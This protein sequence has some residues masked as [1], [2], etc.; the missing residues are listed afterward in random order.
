MK[1]GLSLRIARAFAFGRHIPPGQL[2]RRAALDARRRLFDRIGWPDFSRE[3]APPRRDNPPLPLFSPRGG[4][5]TVGLEGLAFTFLSKTVAMRDAIDWAGPGLGGEHQLWRMNLHYMEYLETIDDGRLIDLVNQWIAGNRLG[6]G[7]WRD[8][9]NSYALSLRA[10]VWM[11]QIAQRGDKKLPAETLAPILASL[12]GQLRFLRQNLETD[13]GGNHLIKN[14]KALAWGAAFFNGPESD[15]WRATALRLLKRE[16]AR[17]ILAD[18]AHYERSPAYHAQVFADLLECRQ[19]LG[20]A[21]P[22]LDKALAGM[23]QTLADLAHPDGMIAQFNDAGLTMAYA[24]GE[25]LAAYAQVF[26][27]APAPRSVFAMKQAGYFGRRAGGDYLLVDCGR[28]APDDLPAHGH[29]DVLSFEWSVAGQRIIVDPGVFEYIAGPRRHWS[30]SALAHNTLCV[31]GADQAD[32]FGAFRCGRRPNVTLRRFEPRADGFALE[33]SHDGFAY[34]PGAPTHV[35]RFEADA[36]GVTIFDR[37]EG[38]GRRSASVRFLF[39]PDVAV[40][41]KSG[42]VLLQCKAAFIEMTS[43]LPIV[44]DEGFWWPDMGV[45][46]KTRFARIDLAGGIKSATSAFRIIR[47]GVADKG[48]VS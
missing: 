18:G 1:A 12:A 4:Q 47:D 43:D 37:V 13:L 19:V 36:A 11:Q 14:I 40:T 44:I 35:R 41:R 15:A 17:Q 3:N 10:V 29:G 22:E 27:Q 32:F 24:P 6:A 16:I 21:A 42:K 28:I 34:L 48:E 23:A 20:D 8:S 45:E 2:A 5:V 39:H 38:G 26:G 25:C 30:R 31:E 33:G 9:W 7:A 46:R